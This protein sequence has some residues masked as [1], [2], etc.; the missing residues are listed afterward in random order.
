MTNIPALVA[1]LP[2]LRRLADAKREGDIDIL[3]EVAELSPLVPDL[4]ETVH[5]I[6][7]G[8]NH[9]ETQ[10]EKSRARRFNYERR[11][12]ARAREFNRR[13]PQLASL[14]YSESDI[15]AKCGKLPVRDPVDPSR[16]LGELK[17]SQAIKAIDEGLAL[18]ATGRFALSS[19]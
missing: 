2:I 13:R 4:E 7:I 8:A 18:I 3:A 6:A 16:F 19:G 5:L 14:G 10:A 15:K 11:K 12:V 9:S 17:R 1:A